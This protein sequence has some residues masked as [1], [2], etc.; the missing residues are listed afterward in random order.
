MKDTKR[1]ANR[2]FVE[3]DS[4]AQNLRRVNIGRSTCT[5]ISSTVSDTRR[6]RASGCRSIKF[7]HC[8]LI[9]GMCRIR[10]RWEVERVAQQATSLVSPFVRGSSGVHFKKGQWLCYSL[11]F[12]SDGRGKCSKWFLLSLEEISHGGMTCRIPHGGQ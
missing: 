9:F 8:F 12:C 5:W 2:D 4:D 11:S 1:I 6:W 3:D 7:I 10:I